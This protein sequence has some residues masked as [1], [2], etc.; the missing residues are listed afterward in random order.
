MWLSA[1]IYWKWKKL[2]RWILNN[3]EIR[4]WMISFRSF[5]LSLFVCRVLCSRGIIRAVNSVCFRWYLFHL[6]EKISKIAVW[7]TVQPENHMKLENCKRVSYFFIHVL[8]W[9]LN[10]NQIPF[11]ILFSFFSFILKD[12]DECITY[13][14]KCH[15]NATCNNT[16]GSHVCSC[17]PGYIGDGR[18]CTGIF[19]SQKCSDSFWQLQWILYVLYDTVESQDLIFFNEGGGGYPTKTFA[20]QAFH[21]DN[22]FY[23]FERISFSQSR[24]DSSH[25]LQSSTR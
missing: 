7:L 9:L 14:G 2:H 8:I 23:T 5:S 11:F 16:D 21:K 1:W 22:L 25:G 13:P 18:S 19:Q 10:K 12:I 24:V 4:S 6:R 15:V 17:K 3:K 20:V